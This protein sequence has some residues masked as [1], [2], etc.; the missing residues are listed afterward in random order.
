MNILL[1]V[2]AMAIIYACFSSILKSYRPEY[3][4]LLRVATIALIFSV[5]VEGISDGISNILAAFTVFNIDSKHIEL[6]LKV[7][8]ITV[9]TDF[10]CDVLKDSGENSMAGIVTVAARI[11]VLV[12]CMPLINSLILFSLKMLE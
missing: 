1:K 10:L 7:V 5:A 6:L 2:A 8:G 12:M 4:L 9:I 3:I 11:I